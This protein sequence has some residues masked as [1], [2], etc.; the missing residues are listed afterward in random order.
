[1]DV[2]VGNYES[3]GAGRASNTVEFRAPAEA[4]EQCESLLIRMYLTCL[5]RNEPLSSCRAD[6]YTRSRVLGKTYDDLLMFFR[7]TGS[8]IDVIQILHRCK[9]F[10]RHL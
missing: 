3:V 9:D 10:E 7:L 5:H 6:R 1:M 8:G 4:Y 2:A